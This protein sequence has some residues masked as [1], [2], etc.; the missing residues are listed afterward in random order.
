[1]MRLDLTL[2]ICSELV[3]ILS[4]AEWNHDNFFMEE[5]C[6]RLLIL[7]ICPKKR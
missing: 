6:E 2:R 3:P 7:D 4:V 5:Q 1:M